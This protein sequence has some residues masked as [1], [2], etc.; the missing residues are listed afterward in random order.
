[1]RYSY[2]FFAIISQLRPKGY[3]INAVFCFRLL[4]TC[5]LL[6]TLGA[7]AHAEPSPRFQRLSLEQGLSQSY[8]VCMAQDKQ[9][10]LWIGTYDGLNRYDGSNIVVYRNVPGDPHSLPDNSI[11]TLHVD[12]DGQLLIGTKNGGL[13]AYDRKTDSFRPFPPDSPY[14]PAETDPEI[15][16]L[17]RDPQGRLWVGGGAGLARL[18]TGHTPDMID[19]PGPTDKACPLRSILA[20]RI[21]PN[22]DVYAATSQ[23]LYRLAN[24]ES[25]VERLLP[26]PLG[27]LPPDARINGIDL[28]GQDTLW[29]LTELHGAYRINLKNGGMDHFLPGLATWFAFRDSRN[30]LYVG[31][32]RGLARF[33]PDPGAP[34]GLRP[35]L[36]ANSPTDPE[37]L[38]QDEV[39]NVLEDAG[40]ILWFGTYSGG[41]NKLNPAYQ[42]FL[43]YRSQ[44]GNPQSLSSNAISAIVLESRDV[45]WIGTRYE[46]LN[47]LDRKTG[48]VTRFR[49][50]PARPGS[51]GGDGVNCLHVD[52]R[53]RL[54]V[55]T[56]DNG[57]DLYDP[58]T[59]EFRHFCH[60]PDNRESIGQNKIW[61][62]AEDAS[63]LLWLGTSSGGLSRFD[64]ET[65]KAK[66]YRHDPDNPQSISH[67]RVR[68]ITPAPDG[69]LWIGTNAGLNRFDPKTELFT[70]WEHDPLDPHS[71]SNNRVTPILIDPAG[72]LWIGTDAGL[73]RFDPASGRFDRITT[74]NGLAN[75]GIQG[76][77]RAPDGDL[78]CSTFRGLSRY[79]PST[80][81]VRNYTERDGLTGLEFWMNAYAAGP[82]GEFFLGTTTG[83]TAFDPEA[84]RANGHI[85]PVVIT[86]MTIRNKP[87]TRDGSMLVAP[88]VTIGYQ[89]NAL[90]FSFA[91]LDY[92]DPPRN[93]FSHKLEGFD[94]DFSPPSPNNTA[95]YTN[96]DPGRYILRVRACN[97][98]GIW[99]DDGVSLAVTV[100]PPYWRTLWFRL[101]CVLSGIA[102][103]YGIYRRRMATAERRRL[104]LEETIRRR[105]ED[106]KNEIEERKG[107]EAAL[108]RSRM[109]FSAIFQFSPLTVTIT[110]EETGKV[111]RVNDA[112]SQLTG[113]P[114][115]SAIGRTSF[116]LGYWDR[117]E[118]RAAMLATLAA[119]ESITNY[120][121]TFR[122]AS[123]RSIVG[124]C[125]AVV[126]DA[127]GKRCLLMLIAD[128]TERKD[129]ERELVAARERAEQANR[130][131]SDFL[132]NMSHEIRTP[133]NA[134]LGM[135][136][137]L[138]ET[139]LTPKQKRFVD[140]FQH[141]GLI[142]LRVI[143]DI[144][145]L[146]KLEAGKLTLVSEAFDL[147][148]AL[149]Q[150]CAVFSS[151][152]EGKGLSL[153][154]DLPPDLPKRAW[155]DTIRL[156]QILANLLANAC[157]FTHAGE[158]RLTAGV[159]AEDGAA[160]PDAFLLR[161]TVSDTGIGI[162]QQDIGRVCDN[163][164][165]AGADRR[166][167]TG[168]GL[169]IAKR[170]A[171]LMQ[172]GLSIESAPGKGTRVTVTVR[173]GRVADDAP[174]PT[175]V[176][177]DMFADLFASRETPWQ[178]LLVDDSAG[179]RQV[180]RLFLEDAP[181]AVTEAENGQDAV[182]LWR[183][184]RF[185]VILMDH[186]M[187]TLDGLAATRVIRDHEARQG[188]APIPIIGITARAFPEDEAACMEAGCSAYLS[189]PVRKTAL[190]ATLARLLLPTA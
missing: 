187:P 35:V 122:H 101:A 107:V 20:V 14:P 168:L 109:S 68:H 157:K 27:K 13:A 126:I 94:P 21:A 36:Y 137:L 2:C 64:P 6:A 112:F 79:T 76:L 18:R 89:E 87:F 46:G 51:L 70:H 141:S 125:S 177:Q 166:N 71:L 43:T 49:H 84:I 73:N 61:W 130:A 83:L 190:L 81:A 156:T 167:G 160:C 41:I 15:R 93:R 154:C 120:E 90:A 77:L 183:E 30:V 186:V 55:G 10:F 164:F 113:I 8:A 124:L 48:T 180:L 172:G 184:G 98:D 22:G 60:D 32:N 105:T 82:D 56:T 114:A 131:K 155:G 86:D 74:Q 136:E 80:G 147:P 181:F 134:I 145:D 19:L 23:C 116:E 162:N 26:G 58:A 175:A 34:G 62:I 123:G 63:G 171:I 178:V 146:S 170:L 37:S 151:Q 44:P 4:C 103:L 142:L 189:K 72:T 143:N 182:E 108:H 111:L 28:D 144:L 173:L 66:T 31:T 7:L 129:L 9:G 29:V 110:E 53:G 135:A 11:R 100:T 47:R 24:G 148:E 42:S 140:I 118:D 69:I 121:V 150:T 45:V 161:L 97:N 54:W 153:Y 33:S 75:D 179:N 25:P 185:D 38:S 17:A 57:L 40:G 169:A 1:M 188:L 65:G 117:Y 12:P 16:T 176:A 115:E 96:L 99:N 149:F 159:L 3:R 139:P 133:M 59:G 165:Q 138:A 88:D 127:F 102:A 67:N 5:V 85:P 119:H 50:D 163:F 39:L 152:A 132:A 78:W 158:I 128:I 52:S 95:A 174:H 91:A 92:A 104:E 106:L